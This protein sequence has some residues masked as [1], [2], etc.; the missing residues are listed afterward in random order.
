M[1]LPS[2]VTTAQSLEYHAFGDKLVH[3]KQA[4][5]YIGKDYL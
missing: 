5:S 2:S 3:D 1:Q 4:K